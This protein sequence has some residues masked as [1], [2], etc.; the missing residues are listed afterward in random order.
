MNSTNEIER[1]KYPVGSRAPFYVAVV[2]LIAVVAAE[3]VAIGTLNDGHVVYTLDDAYIHLSLAEN[4]AQGHYG[5]N[6]NEFSSPSSSIVWPYL[7]APFAGRASGAYA[8][9]VLNVLF[10]TA[11]LYAFF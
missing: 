5:I 6:G 2:V 4:I 8:P 3:L 10:A 9:L 11:A 1:A 7:L